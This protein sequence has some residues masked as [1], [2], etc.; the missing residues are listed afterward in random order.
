MLADNHPGTNVGS[1]DMFTVVHSYEQALF[2]FNSYTSKSHYIS[3]ADYPRCHVKNKITRYESER[4]CLSL[5]APVSASLEKKNWQNRS[6]SQLQNLY[7]S[8]TVVSRVSKRRCMAMHSH[9]RLVHLLIIGVHRS[10]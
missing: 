1:Y 5:H 3:L 8:V 6:I 7:S 4:S 10:A 9:N 2:Q